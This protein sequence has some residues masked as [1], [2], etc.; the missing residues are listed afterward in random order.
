AVGQ[1]LGFRIVGERDKRH[2][3]ISNG[4]QSNDRLAVLA[5]TPSVVHFR[6]RLHCYNFEIPR[7]FEP[8]TSKLYALPSPGRRIVSFATPLVASRLG[9]FTAA[10]GIDCVPI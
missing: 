5:H 4:E 10:P 1:Y 6:T 8:R 9:R 3:A 2:I 7:V